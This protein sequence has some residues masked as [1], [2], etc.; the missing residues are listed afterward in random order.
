M[1]QETIPV[2]VRMPV[3]L[4]AWIKQQAESE[5]RSNHSFILR[6]IEKAKEASHAQS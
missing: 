6:L 5:R 1:K 3:D 4:H 2:T